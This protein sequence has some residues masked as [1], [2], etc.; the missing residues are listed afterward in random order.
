MS[1]TTTEPRASDADPRGA[2]AGAEWPTRC[3]ARRSCPRCR[4]SSARCMRARRE[5]AWLLTAYL[6]SAS[7]GTAIIG[8]LG[9]MYGKERLLLWTLLVLAAGT[10][11]AARVELAGGDRRRPLHPGRQRRHLPARVRDRARRVP[12]R[13]GRRE[14][15]PA[16]GD[17]RRR[18]GHRHRALGGD[19][20]APQL[21]LAVLDPARGDARR[22]SGH[23]EIHPRIAGPVHR[24]ASTGW[25][26]R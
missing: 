8:R 10:L 19:R 22:G 7:V 12:A 5:I 11:L 17:P 6:L 25:P 26:R 2:V 20:R 16:V 9:D 24:D 15:R 1:S 3:S 21:S 4:R 23:L 18:R 13:E 14:H